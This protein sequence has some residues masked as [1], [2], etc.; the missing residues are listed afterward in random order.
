MFQDMIESFI[1]FNVNA[2][3]SLTYLFMTNWWFIFIAIGAVSSMVMMLRDEV[4]SVVKNEQQ[5]L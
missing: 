3:S 1:A 4:D 2:F 5:V